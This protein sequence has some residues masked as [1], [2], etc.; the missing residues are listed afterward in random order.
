[1]LTMT[2]VAMLSS[3]PAA[4]HDVSLMTTEALE[5]EHSGLKWK[6]SPLFFAGGA[7]LM[8]GG[9]FGFVYSSLL[10]YSLS[11][12]YGD[13]WTHRPEREPLMITG[14][15]IAGS[16]LAMIFVG[17][18]LRISVHGRFTEI[19]EELDRR[20]QQADDPRVPPPPAARLP[21]V[22]NQVGVTL[23]RF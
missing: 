8:V 19:S 6:R 9:L 11:L 1:M 13:V 18:A 7:S 23:I 22:P 4:E 16:G 2:L 21:A 20:E 14:V 10:G 15:A 12:T 3:A 17:I 5:A